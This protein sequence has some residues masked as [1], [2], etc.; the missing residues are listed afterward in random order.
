MSMDL[1]ISSDDHMDLHTLPPDLWQER[2]PT[3]WR[4]H[5]PKVETTEKGDFWFCEGESW[6]RCRPERIRSMPSIFDRVGYTNY[7]LRPATPELRLDDM[8]RDHVYAQVIYPGPGGFK[9][10]DPLL[11][12][13]ILKVYNDW[14]AEFNAAAPGRLCNLALL[15]VHEASA[16]VKELRR[17][18]KLGHRGALFDHFSAAVPIFDSSW[19]PLWAASEETGVSISVHIGGGTYSIGSLRAGWIMPARVTVSTMQ[20]DEVLAAMTFCGA[21]ERH[22]GFKLVLGESGLGWV[23]YVLERADHEYHKYYDRMFDYRGE[24]LPSE[25]FARQMY[26]TFEEEELGVRLIPEIGAG[27][28]LWAS[29]YPHPDSTWPDSLAYVDKA[30]EHLD[31]ASR[32]TILWE[33]AA[34]LYRIP[35]P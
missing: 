18:A 24:M 10:Q 12:A 27:N 31:E 32:R 3:A 1:V 30:F 5:G 6:G 35:A 21:L 29:D 14:T 4:E 9:V 34:E 11:K 20:L 7:N 2:L 28:V 15:P 8:E 16:A 17:A 13:E 33:N 22:P 23:P 19:E 25:L 26:V